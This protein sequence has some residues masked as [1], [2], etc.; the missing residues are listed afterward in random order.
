MLR[1][2]NLKENPLWEC[3]P[4]KKLAPAARAR[5]NLASQGHLVQR[6]FNM[7]APY[8]FLDINT[9]LLIKKEILKLLT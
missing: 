4:Q 1:R 5:R 6:Q 9:D 8:L 7:V 3:F 2:E